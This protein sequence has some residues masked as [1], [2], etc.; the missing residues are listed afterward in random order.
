MM[1]KVFGMLRCTK[2]CKIF[3]AGIELHMINEQGD[4]DQVVPVRQRGTDDHIGFQKIK[5][6]DSFARTDGKPNVRIPFEKVRN[7][8]EKVEAD[9]SAGLP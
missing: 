1:V 8:L 5:F 9:K 6:R 2:L 4:L 3:L 7:V